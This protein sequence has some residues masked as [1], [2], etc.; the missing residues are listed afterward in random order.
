MRKN[1][2]RTVKAQAIDAAMQL[3]SQDPNWKWRATVTKQAVRLHWEYLEYLQCAEPYF[4]I[5][6]GTVEREETNRGAEGDFIV[7]RSERGEYLS[8]R[9][10][11]LDD[12][13]NKYCADGNLAECVASLMKQVAKIAHNRY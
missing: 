12:G 2:Y 9:I 7:A 6:D 1:D 5:T 10:V 4:I 13:S 11:L 3:D 8:G